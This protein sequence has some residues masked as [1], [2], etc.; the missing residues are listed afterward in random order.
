[1][2]GCKKGRTTNLPV[3]STKHGEEI[4][5]VI[6]RGG[7]MKNREPEFVVYLL[8]TTKGQDFQILI[9]SKV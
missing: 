2:E 4:F 5:D 9:S 6:K 7:S 1:M 8:F 3:P